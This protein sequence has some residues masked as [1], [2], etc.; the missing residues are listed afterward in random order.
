MKCEKCVRELIDYSVVCVCGH[1][2]SS[3]IVKATHTEVHSGVGEANLIRFPRNSGSPSTASV[4][5]SASTA[6]PNWRDEL[7]ERVRQFR[8]R[9]PEADV[10]ASV[11]TKVEVLHENPV[12]EAALKRLRR[13][14]APP[15]SRS[16]G[17]SS[18][19]AEYPTRSGHRRE[20]AD[21]HLPAHD[22]LDAASQGSFPDYT[23]TPASRPSTKG[24]IRPSA[25][26]SNTEEVITQCLQPLIAPLPAS[27]WDRTL[28]GIFDL[29]LII[30]ACVPLYS[31]HSITGVRFGREAAYATAGIAIWITF[32]YQMWTMLV[33]GR[34]CGMAWRHLRVADAN[35]REF[36][37]P[38]W[39]IFI[40]SICATVSLLLPPVNL[41]AI[42]LSDNQSGLADTLSGTMSYQTHAIQQVRTGAKPS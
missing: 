27:L 6:Q 4:E 21:L 33:A 11:M 9:R 5:E 20:T 40:R 8:E 38:Q 39:R 34:T 22:P 2:N 31:I 37:F 12:V 30:L 18:F 35:T 26:A 15:Q 28:A 14:N 3:Q 32:L 7:K 41:L 13:T 16:G 10:A 17:S 25:G 19:S 36:L 24:S 1:D 23:K 29:A 42:W